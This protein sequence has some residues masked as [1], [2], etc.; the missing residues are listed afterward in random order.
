M[1]T[2]LIGEFDAVCQLGGTIGLWTVVSQADLACDRTVEIHLHGY[3]LQTRASPGGPQVMR[4]SRS[5][6]RAA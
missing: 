2:A 3:D 5:S 1:C 4:Y 6:G